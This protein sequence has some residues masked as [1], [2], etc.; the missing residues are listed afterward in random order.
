LQAKDHPAGRGLPAPRL[1]DQPQGFSL[2]DEE[3]DIVDRLDRPHLTLE[4]EALG[5]GIVFAQVAN[6]QKHVAVCRHASLPARL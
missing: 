4:D 2:A 6:F 5:H 1:A 3:A